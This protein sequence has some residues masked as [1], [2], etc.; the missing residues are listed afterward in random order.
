MFSKAIIQGRAHRLRGQNCQDVAFWRDAGEG[1]GTAVVLDGCGS[2]FQDESGVFPSRNEVGASLLGQFIADFLANHMPLES[3]NAIDDLL[4]QLYAESLRFL[5]GLAD[6][7]PGEDDHYRRRFIMTHLL[8]TVI[9]VVNSP[10]GTVFFWQGDGLLR[11]DRTIIQ[12]NED[13]QPD[14]LAYSLFDNHS[15]RSA[16]HTCHLRA[17]PELLA[18]A[19]DG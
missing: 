1:W 11:V 16:F 6:L 15:Q 9:G 5:E 4:G 2:G 10:A 3:R 12:L 14:Y 17:A 19:T 7:Y 8:C 13:N 18:V